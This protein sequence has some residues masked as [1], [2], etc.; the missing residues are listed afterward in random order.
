[1]K[2]NIVLLSKEIAYAK[3]DL[4]RLQK[5][6]I[7]YAM[8]RIDQKELL[9]PSHILEITVKEFAQ[10]CSATMC[11]IREM[12]KKAEV[13][14]REQE[15]EVAGQKM[16]WFEAMDY[17]PHE[18]R[19]LLRF[20]RK[21]VPYISGLSGY[22]RIPLEQIQQV[23]SKYTY[24]LLELLAV[25]KSRKDSYPSFVI[26]VD[27]FK[28]LLQLKGKCYTE[29]CYI[30]KDILMLAITELYIKGIFTVKLTPVKRGKVVKF[31]QFNYQIH[32]TPN[33]PYEQAIKGLN[34]E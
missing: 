20:D 6:F 27:D 11:D 4:S 17:I 25:N 33:L 13:A 32:S 23:N 29:T 3:Y 5:K 22:Y 26:Q 16:C 34:H 31:Y 30:K 28:E 8:S 12:L 2:K 15:I 1:M 7:Y 19:Y 9:K 14:L 10:F 24:R 18:D 21:I